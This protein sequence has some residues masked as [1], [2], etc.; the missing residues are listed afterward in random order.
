M[1]ES[2]KR[3]HTFRFFCWDTHRSRAQEQDKR[4][5][6]SIS[7]SKTGKEIYIA[8]E[9]ETINLVTESAFLSD[10]GPRGTGDDWELTED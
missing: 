6:K 9:I 4:M 8:P 2:L 1:R 7:E 5:N 3:L 10:S